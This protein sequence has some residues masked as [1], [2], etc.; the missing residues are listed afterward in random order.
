M[1]LVSRRAG[2]ENAWLITYRPS[3]VSAV[4]HDWDPNIS[5]PVWPNS[6]IKHFIIWPPR[7]EN[8][9]NFVSLQIGRE[10]RDSRMRAGQPQKRFCNEIFILDFRV[11]TETHFGL[12]KDWASGGPDGLHYSIY[13]FNQHGVGG[14]PAE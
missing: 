5:L 13:W 9:Q 12:T 11:R 8:L 14:S 1:F 2:H 3:T 7:V 6:V 10:T 4:C